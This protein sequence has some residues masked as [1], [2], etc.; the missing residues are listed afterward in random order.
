MNATQV[1][2]EGLAAVTP[3]AVRFDPVKNRMSR[4][5]S[6]AALSAGMDA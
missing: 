3:A 1:I 2:L 6:G 5:R 4:S